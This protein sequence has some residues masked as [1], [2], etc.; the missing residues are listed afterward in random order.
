[1]RAPAFCIGL[2]WCITAQASHSY[3]GL[4]LCSLYP[5]IMPPGMQPQDLPQPESQGA[6]LLQTYCSQC[7]ALPGP[8]EH[9]A[10]EWPAVLGRMILLMDVA[11]RFGGLMGNIKVA[12]TGE[13]DVLRTYLTDNALHALSG[14]P[15]GVGS[16][17]Y[18]SHCGSCHA[19][20]DAGQYGREEWPVILQRMQHNMT[21]MK[22]SPPSLEVMAQI[23]FYL[24]Q[25]TSS[26]PA[27]MQDVSAAATSAE[28][29]DSGFAARGLF[30]RRR[31]MAL[32]PFLLLVAVGLVRWWQG[33]VRA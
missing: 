18:A 14:E 16:A 3:G 24:Q 19:L 9:T 6:S 25:N 27:T 23:Q 10:G 11:S 20:P 30:D 8:G 17:A 22:Y 2:F 13:G 7:H 33:R 32:G 12:S 15:R 28:A 21:V 26:R 31:W 29:G 1:M 5:E 4:D